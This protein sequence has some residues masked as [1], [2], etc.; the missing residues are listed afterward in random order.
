MTQ[1]SDPSTYTVMNLFKV[2]FNPINCRIEVSN[3]QTGWSVW[4][5]WIGI[6][7]ALIGFFI[8]APIWLGIIGAILGIISLWGTQKTWAWI[9]IIVGVIVLIWGIWM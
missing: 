2:V 6:V 1:L 5:S 4:L 7:V 3:M 8:V 9:A